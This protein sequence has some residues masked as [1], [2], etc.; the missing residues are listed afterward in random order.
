METQNILVTVELDSLKVCFPYNDQLEFVLFHSRRLSSQASLG[1]HS[2]HEVAGTDNMSPNTM[3]ICSLQDRCGHWSSLSAVWSPTY[4]L[5]EI[6]ACQYFLTEAG[7][8][9][10]QLS[11]G[12]QK[13]PVLFE[14]IERWRSG[15]GRLLIHCPGDFLVMQLVL[16][17][18]GSLR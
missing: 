18:P 3:W 17:E 4:D 1:Q 13:F 2:C 6:S 15:A 11:Q 5:C 14:V 9:S 8:G 7:S 12:P 16:N 10:S